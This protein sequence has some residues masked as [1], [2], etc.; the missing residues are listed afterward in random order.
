MAF[1]YREEVDEGKIS[2]SCQY[3]AHLLDNTD[4]WIIVR[5]NPVSIRDLHNHRGREAEDRVMSRTS[6]HYGHANVPSRM[7]YVMLWVSKQVL[8]QYMGLIELQIAERQATLATQGLLKYFSLTVGALAVGLKD[9]EV[10]PAD[11]AEKVQEC[12]RYA[13]QMSKNVRTAL[14]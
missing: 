5:N 1:T 14:A 8:Q 13:K 2:N 7:I 9:Q 11:P 6:S 3:I 12:S 4:I 10:V